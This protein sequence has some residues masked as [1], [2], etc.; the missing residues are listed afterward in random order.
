MARKVGRPALDPLDPSAQICLSVP[1]KTYDRWDKAARDE[2]CSIQELI[3]R[4]LLS[5]ELL[6]E[7]PKKKK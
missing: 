3:R 4:A 1:G 2:R 6:E 5:A 7:E